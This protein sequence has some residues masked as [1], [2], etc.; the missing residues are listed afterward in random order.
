MQSAGLVFA[1]A[2]AVSLACV[3][4]CDAAITPP[5]SSMVRDTARQFLTISDRGYY[6]EDGADDYEGNDPPPPPARYSEPPE[7][8]AVPEWLPPPRP[9]NCGQYKYW[10][11]AYCADARD[12]PP[13][14]GPRW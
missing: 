3:P 10:N 9:A 6:D 12:E 2:I 7:G 11:G 13:Y 4:Q 8:D 5:A 14:V 1:C